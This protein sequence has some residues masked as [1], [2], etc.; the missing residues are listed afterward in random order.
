MFTS[1]A[2]GR[3]VRREADGQAVTYASPSSSG[4]FLN[5]TLRALVRDLQRPLVA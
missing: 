2:D 4:G 1:T 3:V 5:P